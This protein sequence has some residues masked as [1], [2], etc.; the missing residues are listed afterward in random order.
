MKNL[1]VHVILKLVVFVVLTAALTVLA[2]VK[3]IPGADAVSDIKALGM[4]LIGGLAAFGGASKIAD[5]LSPSSLDSK[6][7]MRM[8]APFTR[9]SQRSTPPFGEKPIAAICETCPH[10]E[11]K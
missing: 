1:D 4:A 7:T 10:K 3:V 5:A 6:A 2:A 8:L 9:D 11:S